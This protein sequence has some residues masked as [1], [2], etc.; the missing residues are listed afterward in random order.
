M[1]RALA[2][3]VLVA[4]ANIGF[5][6]DTTPNSVA[7]ELSDNAL[8]ERLR[9]GGLVLVVRHGQTGANPDRPDAITGRDSYVGVTKE[10]QAAYFDCDR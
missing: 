10:R 6:Q 3:I 1:N 2:V 7:P 5:A 8:L 4:I 9:S